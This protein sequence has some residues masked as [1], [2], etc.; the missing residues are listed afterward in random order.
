ML[1]SAPMALA[2]DYQININCSD[3]G[4]VSVNK[5]S[6]TADAGELIKVF[7]L[8]ESNLWALQTF[9]VTRQDD[10]TAVECADY[11]DPHYQAYSFAMP[12]C[13]VTIDVAFRRAFFNV[14][15]S[16]PT[17]EGAATAS[18]DHAATGDKVDV[19]V[20]PASGFH[21]VGLQ[22]KE[23]HTGHYLTAIKNGD[24]Q[25]SFTIGWD[26]VTITPQF[27]PTSQH[28]V[29]IADTENGSI[30]TQR[31]AY[32][33]DVV[34]FFT[35]PDIGYATESVKGT[36]TKEVAVTMPP[37]RNIYFG[38]TSFTRSSRFSRIPPFTAERSA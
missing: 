31:S 3:G 27:A 25:Y 30:E 13:D 5:K 18:V 12:A 16:P 38:I 11:Y 21:T 9:S 1:A 34:Y 23:D 28:P 6:G 37:A 32:E 19:E 33:G 35:H 15:M 24:N 10:G 29:H 14:A 36:V 20:Y 4:S 8:P 7:I 2:G 17:D 22:V 26:D